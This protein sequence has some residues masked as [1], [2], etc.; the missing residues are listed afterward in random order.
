MKFYRIRLRVK[1]I[2]HETNILNPQLIIGAESEEKAL[3][4]A[5]KS[6]TEDNTY[7]VLKVHSCEEVF[8]SAIFCDYAYFGSI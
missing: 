6:W 1:D 2:F 8:P 4:L 5:K 7:E 3:Y